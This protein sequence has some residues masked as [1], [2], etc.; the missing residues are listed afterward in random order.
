MNVVIAVAIELVPAVDSIL[1]PP[2]IPPIP[3]MEIGVPPIMPSMTPS[4]ASFIMAV[5]IP[6]EDGIP[7][8]AA[9]CDIAA[10]AMP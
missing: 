4:D 1:P 10:I 2:I 9:Y 6:E 8:F 5:T 3:L 7:K